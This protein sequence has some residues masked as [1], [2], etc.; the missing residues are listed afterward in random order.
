MLGKDIPVVI[1]DVLDYRLE[2]AERLGGIPVRA[3]ED[4]LEREW[5]RHVAAKAD[6]AFDSSGRTSARQ[7]CLA[8][9][10]QRRAL[11]CVGHGGE[12]SLQV[13]PDLIAA[14]RAYWAANISLSESW[15]ATPSCCGSIGAICGRSL[16]TVIRFGSFR[17]PPIYFL[18]DLAGK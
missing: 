12:L 16:P 6:I 2:L 8:L 4:S 15:P 14:E 5:S 18:P 9:L 10:G 7:Q 3:D 17:R 13:S 1:T 11:V